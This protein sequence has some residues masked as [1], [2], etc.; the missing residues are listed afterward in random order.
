L[1]IQGIPDRLSQNYK[2]FDVEVCP[3]HQLRRI[4]VNERSALTLTIG[5]IMKATIKKAVMAGFVSIA[6]AGLFGCSDTD[7]TAAY[8]PPVEVVHVPT[9]VTNVPPTANST[10]VTTNYG[11]GTVQRQTTTDYQPGY[12]TMGPP[13]ATTVV[14]A[15]PATT[16]T[17]QTTVTDY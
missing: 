15:V 3:A 16:T 10:T 14:P 9:A 6:V 11:N 17:R 7:T 13:Y 8:N 12:T 1:P 5:E 4:C 2:R